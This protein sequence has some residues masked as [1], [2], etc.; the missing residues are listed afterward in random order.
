MSHRTPLTHSHQTPQL[1]GRF[2]HCYRAP[3]STSQNGA[4]ANPGKRN[5]EADT[6]QHMLC[7][8]RFVQHTVLREVWAQDQSRTREGKKK[9]CQDDSGVSA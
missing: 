4:K 1:A 3:G 5:A 2:P 7:R 9:N 6:T 8:A